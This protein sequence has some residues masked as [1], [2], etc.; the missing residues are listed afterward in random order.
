MFEFGPNANVSTHPNIQMKVL[1]IAILD[2]AKW[3]RKCGA[4]LIPSLEIREEFVQMQFLQVRRP[5]FF[6]QEWLVL[7]K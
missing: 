5:D 3:T 1:E 2:L 4:M 7:R 6:G